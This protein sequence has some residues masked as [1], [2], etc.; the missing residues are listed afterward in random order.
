MKPQR[1]VKRLRAVIK[2]LINNER[3]KERWKESWGKV[4]KQV[5]AGRL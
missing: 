3:V 1:I 5:I 4:N 2:V